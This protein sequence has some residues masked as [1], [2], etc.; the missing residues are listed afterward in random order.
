[1]KPPTSFTS[2]HD[3]DQLDAW[4]DQA[5]AYQQNPLQDQHLGRGKT[6]GLLFFNPS[7]RTRLS[8]LRAA[9]NLGLQP[10]V[11]DMNQHGWQLE[12]A[13]GTI[14]NQG[15]AEHIREGAAVI[16]QYC[17]LI[18]IR[19]FPSLTDRETDYA[20]QVLQQFLTH[21]TV[22]VFSMESATLH[23]LQ[24]FTDL[25]TIREYQRKAQPKIVLTWAPH[26][27]ALPQAVANSF[28]QWMNAAG[29]SVTIT[30]PPGYELKTEF[31]EG[32]PITHQQREALAGADF[33]YT[34]NWSTYAPYG[35]IPQPTT[36]WMVT[37]DKMSLTNNGYFMH[38][39][40]VRRNVVV[41]DAVLDSPQSLVIEQA[42]NRTYAAQVVLRQLLKGTNGFKSA[43]SGKRRT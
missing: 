37:T 24:S 29:H 32:H 25:L 1:M 19:T 2:V 10:I 12:F 31:T 4:L 6:V 35:Q 5:V 9:Y 34:K 33:V 11:M 13:D 42:N 20:E 28:L 17:D 22:P 26:P 7:L 15:K 38:C 3:V 41:T 8:T 39:L 27:K 21:T 14:M 16:S 40:P 43:S 36:D 23:P 30:H 18:G